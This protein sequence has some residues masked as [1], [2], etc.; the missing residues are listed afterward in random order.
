MSAKYQIRSLVEFVRDKYTEEEGEYKPYNEKYFKGKQGHVISVSDTK[1]STAKTLEQLAESGNAEYMYVVKVGLSDIINVPESDIINPN[2]KISEKVEERLRAKQAAKE[3]KD[4]E[5]R[6]G[7]S[8]KEKRAYQMISLSDLNAIEND[9]ATAIELVKKDKVYPKVDVQ[10][11]RESGNSSGAVFLK[12]KL[13]E[14]YGSEPPNNKD[15]RKIYVGYATYLTEAMQKITSVKEFGDFCHSKTVSIGI[16]EILR[17]LK[18]E[19][20][21]ESDGIRESNKIKLEEIEDEMREI[22]N[23]KNDELKKIKAS[24]PELV[25]SMGDFRFYEVP[26]IDRA[27]Y[28]KYENLWDELRKEKYLYNNELTSIEHKFLESLGIKSSSGSYWINRQI[29]EEVFGKRFVNFITQ[30]SNP[31]KETFEQAKKYEAMSVS[32]S[33]MLIENESDYSTKTIERKIKQNE[34][35]GKLV[36][37][38]QHDEYFKE[39]GSMG[40]SGGDFA[41][42]GR[43]Y[44][45]YKDIKVIDQIEAYKKRYIL[46][47]NSTIA[48]EQKRIDTLKEKYKVRDNDWSWSEKKG[49]DG[50]DKKDR[51]ELKVNTYPPLSYIKRTGGV[52]IIDEDITPDS[53]RQKFGFKEVEFGQ[54]LKDKEAK[55]HIRHFLGAMADL[56]EIL[57]MNVVELN[58]LGGLSIA[59]ASRGGGKASAH[60]EPLRKVINVT[61]TRGGGAIAHEYMHYL[62]NILPK[63]GRAEYTYKDW[64]SVIEESRY[65]S[66]RRGKIASDLVFKAVDNIFEYI[67][68]R[69][70]PMELKNIPTSPMT[71]E[72]ADKFTEAIKNK[73]QE[74]VIVKKNIDANTRGFS[75]PQ[76]FYTTWSGNTIPTDIDTYFDAFKNRYSQYRF[77]D[78]LSKRDIEILGAI[79]HKFGFKNYEFS[80]ESNKSRYYANSINMSSDYWSRAWELFARAFETYIFDKLEKS[81]RANNYLVSGA[82]FEREEGVYPFG[83]ERKDLFVLYEALMTAIKS[84]YKI[85]DFVAWTAERVDEYIALEVDKDETVESGVIIDTETEKVEEI[86]ATKNETNDISERKFQAQRKLIALYKLLQIDKMEKGGLIKENETITDKLLNFAN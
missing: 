61:K 48:H 25:S 35:I 18:P 80:F 86:I 1:V 78:N 29:F 57:N 45:Y 20:I 11:E 76:S 53:I 64:A 8:K 9:E 66:N 28:N 32:E 72:E 50:V 52:K 71:S 3:F 24:H 63:I 42:W 84:E 34:E 15:K 55:E 10:K 85:S 62:D 75:L 47:N 65:G 17:I 12:V 58:K 26:E 37:K 60:Y 79:V 81:G 38:E 5:G 83:D 30:G 21:E 43:G 19:L 59:F 33:I 74:K 27:E 6:I 36:T 54:S 31:V 69:K 40:F 41:K 67:Y 82:Y 39:H 51:S 49:G 68:K 46:S 56:A 14:A 23:K 13:R 7:G 73:A 44:F 77:I 2:K 4:T 16:T 70:F 22:D